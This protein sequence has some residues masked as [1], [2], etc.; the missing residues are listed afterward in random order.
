MPKHGV[1][2]QSRPVRAPLERDDALEVELKAFARV[3]K[4]PAAS[5]LV[6]AFL[7]KQKARGL[8]R[9]TRSR[10]INKGAMQ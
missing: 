2:S 7:A 5:E 1:R 8:T 4:A 3:V 6:N 10:S 9:Q